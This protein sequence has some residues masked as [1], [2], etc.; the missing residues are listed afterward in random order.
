MKIYLSLGAIFALLAVVLGAFGAHALKTH[1]SPELLQTYEIGVRYQFYHAFALCLVFV[2]RYLPFGETQSATLNWA[3]RCFVIGIILFSGSLYLLA[4]REM[5]NLPLVFV[6][7]LTP[8]GGAFFIA[9]WACV[10]KASIN[11]DRNAD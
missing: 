8:L 2:L 3:G 7:P 10:F 11:Q 9:G 5:I 4:C 1:L 6:G